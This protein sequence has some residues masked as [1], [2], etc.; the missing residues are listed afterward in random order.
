[1]L[2]GAEA[3]R[4]T[5]KYREVIWKFINHQLSAQDFES[6][7]L[8]IFKHDEDQSL[9]PEFDVLEALFFDVD[10]YVADP[11][12]RREVHGLNDEEL[13]HRAREAYRKL[14]KK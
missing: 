1:M 3:E 7:Y 10:D 13:R 5:A 12:L 9:S 11:G 8:E 6:S 2:S 4:M 14:Y